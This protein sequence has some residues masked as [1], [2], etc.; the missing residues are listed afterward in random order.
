MNLTFFEENIKE[1]NSKNKHFF[2][3]FIHGLELKSYTF[4][5]YK[6]KKLKNIRVR[7]Y[8]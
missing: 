2:D 1:L 7:Y 5:K 6:T 3:E 8:N 4:N